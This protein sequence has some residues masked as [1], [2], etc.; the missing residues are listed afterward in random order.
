MRAVIA[1]GVVASATCL[2]CGGLPAGPSQTTTP[3]AVTAPAPPAP[4]A[5]SLSLSEVTVRLWHQRTD[6][7]FIYSP[8]VL[9]VRETSGTAAATVRSVE[10]TTP[11]GGSDS[12]CNGFSPVRIAAGATV[13][14]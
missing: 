10:V 9:A 5:S 6:T 11:R 8:M 7:D 14:V 12:D 13:D 3:P 1:L 2:G 4:A